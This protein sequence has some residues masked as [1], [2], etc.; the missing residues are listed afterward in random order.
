MPREAPVTITVVLIVI[1]GPPFS[2]SVGESCRL[3]VRADNHQ[4][5]VD[6]LIHEKIPTALA[7]IRKLSRILWKKV[8]LCLLAVDAARAVFEG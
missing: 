5:L 3:C 8:G 7:E 4:L 1:L 6:I 2:E